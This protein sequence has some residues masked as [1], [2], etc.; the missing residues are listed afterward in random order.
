MSDSG[1]IGV[2]ESAGLSE[3]PMVSVCEMLDSGAVSPVHLLPV[4]VQAVQQSERA[5]LLIVRQC[6]ASGV[7]WRAIGDQLGMSTQGAHQR[8]ARLI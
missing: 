1:L 3:L 6:R 4:A 8:F 2:C 5:L 7:S